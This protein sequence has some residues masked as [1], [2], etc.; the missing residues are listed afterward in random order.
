MSRLNTEPNL[1][2]HDNLYERL[3]RLHDGLSDAESMKVWARLVLLLANHIGD[4]D[5]IEDAIALAAPDRPPS[6]R[7]DADKPLRP[8]AHDD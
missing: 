5:V 6:A 7:E 3:V 8:L 2:D 1:T 4:R